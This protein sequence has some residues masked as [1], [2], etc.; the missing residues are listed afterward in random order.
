M[1]YRILHKM[2]KHMDIE[3]HSNINP[4]MVIW[5]G[6][7]LTARFIILKYCMFSVIL[8]PLND[9]L[10]RPMFWRLLGAKVGKR[11][12]IGY[13]VMIDIG[14]THLITVEDNVTITNRCLLLCHK[15]DLEG[16]NIGVD[17]TTLPHK[18]E[19]IIL[20]RNS[21]LGYG[22]TVMPGV[23][24]GEGAMVGAGSLVAN[25]IPAW[26]IAI[27]VPAKVVKKL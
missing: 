16:I 5:Y 9:R 23:I 11:V 12:T 14:N 7:K 21:Y 25:D 20:K 13:D 1:T 27:G 26:T 6:I 3:K 22:V 15:R 10:L 18:L 24:I 8:S 4:F 19:P 2:G 17:Y